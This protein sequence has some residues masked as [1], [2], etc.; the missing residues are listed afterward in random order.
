MD[1]YHRAPRHRRNGQLEELLQ[2]LS[3]LIAPGGDQRALLSGGPRYPVV[4]ITGVP[5]SGST[6]L[7]QWLANSGHF[8]APTNLVSRF[9][10]APCVGALVDR[11]L[12]ESKMDFRG[13]LQGVRMDA[14]V[15]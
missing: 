5:R 12:F 3:E 11:M 2:S 9:W 14:S 13:E 7:L 10:R 15:F 8:R 1:P 6:M 4:F